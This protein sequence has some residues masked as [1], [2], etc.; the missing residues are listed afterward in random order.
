[1]RHVLAQAHI[2][3]EHQSRHFALDRARRL[4]HDSVLRPCSRRDFIFLVRQ[5]KQNHRRHSQR[6]NL[7]RL[8]H[9]LIHRQVE[10]ARHGANFFANALPGTDEH[11]IDKRVGSEP[12]F[13]HHVAEFVRAAKAA[14]AGDRKCHGKSPRKAAN[15]LP[16]LNSRSSGLEPA[17]DVAKC[18]RPAPSKK[19]PA[20]AFP[21]ECDESN[22]A[23]IPP[24]LSNSR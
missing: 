10:H 17:P 11:R 13:A 16:A 14:E 15:R 6:M 18:S 22:V 23:R 12:R 4:L 24:E 1:M 5:A 3:H 19:R 21:P 9:R 8:L 2:A 7:P 20:A